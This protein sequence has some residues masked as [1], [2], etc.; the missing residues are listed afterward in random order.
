MD[1]PLNGSVLTPS[2]SRLFH[3]LKHET[4]R[5][6][7]SLRDWGSYQ[8]TYFFCVVCTYVWRWQLSTRNKKIDF[9]K[10]FTEDFQKNWEYS[11]I[12]LFLKPFLFSM[13]HKPTDKSRPQLHFCLSVNSGTFIWWLITM[14]FEER[15]A[16]TQAA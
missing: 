6:S 3:S 2:Q 8:S 13:N 7:T 5:F 10:V 14:S 4:K 1:T 16:E 15:I 11:T 12:F 9:L